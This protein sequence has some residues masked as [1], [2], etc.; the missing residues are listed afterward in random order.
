MNVGGEERAGD[1][2]SVMVRLMSGDGS[3]NCCL[4]MGG[5]KNASQT[6]CGILLARE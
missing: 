1:V 5:W 4:G 3:T 2:G 6:G